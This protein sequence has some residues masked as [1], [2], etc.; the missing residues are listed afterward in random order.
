MSCLPLLSSLPTPTPPPP[1]PPPSP[2]PIAQDQELAVLRARLAAPDS[3]DPHFKPPLFLLIQL[4]VPFTWNTRGCDC[5]LCQPQTHMLNV[6]AGL[7]FPVRTSPWT[8]PLQDRAC[9]F[10]HT[11]CTE[12]AELH[13]DSFWVCSVALSRSR[14]RVGSTDLM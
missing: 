5:P 8:V 6:P 1:P 4:W 10:V 2:P 14:C 7:F 9:L 13:A 12:I 3:S 11:I